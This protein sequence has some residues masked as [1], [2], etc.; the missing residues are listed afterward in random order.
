MSMYIQ[1]KIVGVV[2]KQ[3]KPKKN[4]ETGAIT[5]GNYYGVVGVKVEGVDRDGFETS[6]LYR[7]SVFG[8][9]YKSRLHDTYRQL[10]GQEALVP[11]RVSADNSRQLSY[12]LS[13]IPLKPASETFAPA[14]KSPSELI[15][16]AQATR[17]AQQ[18][19]IS[20]P[21]APQTAARA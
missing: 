18:E 3:A 2:D 20:K 19:Q 11:V 5:Q 1:G 10:V 8:D 12:F 21:P 7:L 15:A 17:A 4:E 6:A 13:G 14:R 9:D 16:Q